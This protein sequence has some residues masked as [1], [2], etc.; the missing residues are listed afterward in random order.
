MNGR[1]LLFIMD[2]NMIKWDDKYSVN[3]SLIDEQHKKL[4]GIINK[5]IWVENFSNPI[6]ILEILDHMTVYARKHFETEEHYMKKFNFARFK[7]HRRKH[8]DFVNTVLDFKKRAAGG[9]YK[10]INE[11]LEY[12]KQ[13][14]INHI[15]GTDKKYVDCFNENGL[16]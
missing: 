2:N 4:I 7:T 13:W 5:T 8:I 11:I 10:I 3:I 9:D 15:Q 12:L 6:I 16:K 14:F 1:S